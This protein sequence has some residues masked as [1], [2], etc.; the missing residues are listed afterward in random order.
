M[1][2]TRRLNI[3]SWLQQEGPIARKHT[4]WTHPILVCIIHYALVLILTCAAHDWMEAQY[5]QN[6][7]TNE[8]YR[9][10]V[11]DHA[12]DPKIPA[13]LWLYSL[14]LLVWRLLYHQPRRLANCVWYEFTWLCNVTL[15]AAAIALQ[16]HRPI[17]AAAYCVTVGIDQL[18]WYVDVLT[19][20]LIGKFP[21]GVCK[22]LFWPETTFWT[23]VTC[24]HHL[25]TIPLLLT[26]TRGVHILALPLSFL[27]MTINVVSSRYMIPFHVEV[28]TDNNNTKKDSEDDGWVKLDQ[29]QRS[30]NTNSFGCSQT[31]STKTSSTVSASSSTSSS[32][33]TAT[34]T[35]ST[36]V[37]LP[38]PTAVKYLNV[39]LSHEL[40]K[41]ITFSILQ[42]NYDDPPAWLYLFRLL[43]RWQ[44]FNTIVFLILYGAC[45]R[46][47]GAAPIC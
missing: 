21:V 3:L 37:P 38:P 1:T 42:I 18:I 26:A 16:T 39:N 31:Y 35:T 45:W 33:T 14:W 34:T 20:L 32:T 25:W 23:R 8:T 22:Y 47:F 43:W 28:F 12:N 29:Q 36:Y 9:R 7:D 11:L 2:F 17:L 30:T 46:M 15:I 6:S 41:D 40:W 27:A 19:Y 4:E 5:Y 44:G 24:T 13:F 10:C